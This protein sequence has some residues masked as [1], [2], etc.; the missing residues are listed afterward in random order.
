MATIGT[1]N[2]TIY[3]GDTFK[4]LQFTVD[5]NGSVKDLTNTIITM[6]I[7][8]GSKTGKIAKSFTS[9]ASAGLTKTDPTEGIF[10]INPFLANIEAGIYY[11]DVQ[12]NDSGTIKTYIQ[13]IITVDQDVTS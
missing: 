1:K 8:A 5:V 10:I 2:F 3:K 6:E 4:G 9:V 11:Y 7:R 12:F 13:G